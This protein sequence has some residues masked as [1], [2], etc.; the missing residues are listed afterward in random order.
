MFLLIVE[1]FGELLQTKKNNLFKKQKGSTKVSYLYSYQKEV[2]IALI[3]NHC[4]HL[5]INKEN[6]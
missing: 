6:K 1:P 3:I 4:Y 5:Q 2:L